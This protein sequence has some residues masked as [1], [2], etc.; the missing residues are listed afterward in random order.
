MDKANRISSLAER[1]CE[2]WRIANVADMV[3]TL[4]DDTRRRGLAA[5][6][7]GEAEWGDSDS[8]AYEASMLWREVVAL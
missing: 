1:I 8:K 6:L 2:Y 4:W 5:D 7:K 3:A